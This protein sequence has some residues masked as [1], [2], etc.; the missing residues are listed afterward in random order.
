FLGHLL[1]LLLERLLQLAVLGERR[2]QAGYLLRI[3][4]PTWGGLGTVLFFLFLFLGRRDG[5]GQNL[6][7][8]RAGN[9]KAAAKSPDRQGNSQHRS[10][11]FARRDPIQCP[12]YTASGQE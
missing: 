10:L 1:Q 7:A 9:G 4:K 5:L 8:R 3:G 11:L 6:G 2:L 12:S